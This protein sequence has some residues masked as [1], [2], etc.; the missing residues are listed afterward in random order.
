MRVIGVGNILLSDEG[1]GVHLVN[2]FAKRG[3]HPGIDF[4]DG[5]VSG[6]ALLSLIE[7]QGRVILLDT[8]AA[9]FPPGT[10]LKLFP[11]DIRRSADARY[12]LHDLNLADVIDLMR[13]RGTLP[14]MLILGVVPADIETW[15]IG[16]SEPLSA[17]LEEILAKV[18][19]E[20]M[21]FAGGDA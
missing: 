12:S 16:L 8:V 15:R 1:V 14:E 3:T 4:V 13:L 6:G 19:A 2:E 11:D 18:G 9:P 10:V 17:K 7:D 21:K 5:G 20:I